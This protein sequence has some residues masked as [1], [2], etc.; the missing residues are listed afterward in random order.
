MRFGGGGVGWCGRP[1]LNHWVVCSRQRNLGK[2]RGRQG[3]HLYADEW[4]A[5]AVILLL[6][7]C[8]GDGSS[9]LVTGF[10]CE[11][12]AWERVV[13]STRHNQSQST[14]LIPFGSSGTMLGYLSNLGR[15]GT[16]STL[17]MS[18][19]VFL[20]TS[21]TCRYCS[22]SGS[23]SSSPILLFSHLSRTL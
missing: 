4:R 16:S 2:V 15:S 9:C 1:D 6:L 13:A 5:L 14:V 18:S 12:A 7:A 23:E 17:P 10:C 21:T 3:Y 8:G 11:N 19:M 20:I 22:I